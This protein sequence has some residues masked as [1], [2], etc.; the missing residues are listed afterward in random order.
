MVKSKVTWQVICASFCCLFRLDQYD[1]NIPYQWGHVY[2]ILK[3]YH[4]L[5]KLFLIRHLWFTY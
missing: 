5:Q 4:L 3:G 2:L 1:F